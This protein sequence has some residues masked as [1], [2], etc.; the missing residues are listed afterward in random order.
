[1]GECPEIMVDLD[2][3]TYTKWG[4]A[5][6]SWGDVAICM[7]SLRVQE[8][9][10][11]RYDLIDGVILQPHTTQNKCPEKKKR[12]ERTK[13]KNGFVL[14][15]GFCETVFLPTCFCAC[16]DVFSVFARPNSKDPVFSYRNRCVC[17]KIYRPLQNPIVLSGP[18]LL[19]P[20]CTDVH[21]CIYIYAY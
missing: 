21:R 14:K 1:M 19:L 17:P 11:R 13:T 20:C 10:M 3:T 4:G 15:A 9:D 5:P 12:K 8:Y 18:P 6:K 2:Q 16:T 7:G